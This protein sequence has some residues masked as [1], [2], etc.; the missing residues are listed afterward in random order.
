[1]NEEEIY[2]VRLPGNSPIA[3]LSPLAPVAAIDL[4]RST[5]NQINLNPSTL[6]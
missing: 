1:M 5:L 4:A 3:G 6:Y 2:R